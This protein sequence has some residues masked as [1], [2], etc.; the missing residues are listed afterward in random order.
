MKMGHLMFPLK[1]YEET[2]NNL[3]TLLAAQETVN[4]NSVVMSID[5]SQLSGNVQTAI[6]TIQQLET[7][8]EELNVQ[9][10]LKSQGVDI[11]TSA[12][13]RKVSELAAQVQGLDQETKVT[14]GIDTESFDQSLSAIHGNV[15]VGATIFPSDLENIQNSIKGITGD[16]L[17]KFGVDKTLVDSYTAE[18]KDTT[19]KVKYTVD[20]FEV[21]TFLAT[22]HDTTAELTYNVR[23][24]G[25]G[26]IQRN[27]T[28]TITY[29]A[30]TSGTGSVNGTAH[31]LGTV[32][33]YRFNGVSGPAKLSGDWGIKKGGTSLV[34]EL[35]PEILVRGSEFHTIWG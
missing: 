19:A 33:S 1:G 15:Q 25:M 21:D 24:V 26:N 23:V 9:N 16:A 7:A 10:Q 30:T 5:T 29:N 31:A 17:V 32:K 35:G 28:G 12:A 11:D 20:D 8:I 27:I 6:D 4:N 14:L 22:D 13:S 18:N 2:L 34:G 3:Q